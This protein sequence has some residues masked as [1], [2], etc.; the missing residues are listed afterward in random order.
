MQTETLPV[1]FRVNDPQIQKAVWC[2][3]AKYLRP[4]KALGISPD[5]VAQDALIA[6]SGITNFDR[7]KSSPT[8]YASA[9]AINKA[10]DAIKATQR[11]V[12]RERRVFERA[13]HSPDAVCIL[14]INLSLPTKEYVIQVYRH[15]RC[16]MGPRRSGR[17]PQTYHRAQL[18]AMIAVKERLNLSSRKTCKWF[19]ARPDVMKAINL[20]VLPS[21]MAVQRSWHECT[22]TK[23]INLRQTVTNSTSKIINE[24]DVAA[25]LCM[26]YNTLRTWRVMGHCPVPYL[27]IRGN[28]RYRRADVEK[29][30]ESATV[31]PQVSA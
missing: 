24:K 28:I 27:K 4:F 2:A 12:A 13:I 5:D 18:A 3:A 25:L 21:R 8:T 19:T 10:K 6:I 9:I 11:K 1:Q 22:D 23:R 29:Y 20:S 15:A 30:I 26:S 14:P 16:Q 31:Q 7:S 17:G